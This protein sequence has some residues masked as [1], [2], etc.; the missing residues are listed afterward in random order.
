MVNVDKAVI[1]KLKKEGRTFEVLVDCDG[2]MALKNGKN[3]SMKDVL[4]ADK[5]FSDS[6]KGL[7]VSESTLSSLFGT[8]DH[9]EIAKII[10]NDGEVQLTADYR[11]KLKEQK[12]K[13]IIAQI[14]RN[15]IDPKS[16]LPHPMQRLELA[17]EEAR[18]KIDEFKPEEKQIQ[19]ILDKLKLIIPISFAKK[20]ISIRV[21]ATTA[22]KAYGHLYGSLESFGK[23]IKNEWLNDGSW[24]AVVEIPAGM[25]NDLFD[26]VNSLTQGNA[27]INILKTK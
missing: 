2:A 1:A 8:S 14:H 3:V 7:V 22:A 6:K 23:V 25:Q 10:I 24:F 4:A 17:F 27:E 9:D 12:K 20:E 5:I 19:E 26:K 18:I 21:P 11:T 15:G 16:G 13:R